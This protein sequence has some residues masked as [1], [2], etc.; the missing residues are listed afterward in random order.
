MERLNAE[1]FTVRQRIDIVVA[2]LL[3]RDPPDPTDE[4]QIPDLEAERDIYGGELYHD[5]LPLYRRNP[6]MGE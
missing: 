3:E 1:E 4:Q 2:R 6:Y 5:P